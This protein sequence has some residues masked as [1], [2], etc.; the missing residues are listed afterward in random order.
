MVLAVF[1]ILKL[2]II[3]LER[4]IYS[5]SFSDLGALILFPEVISYE[6]ARCWHINLGQEN[7]SF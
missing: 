6:S 4:V 7:V 2:K 1:H 3:Y 5:R